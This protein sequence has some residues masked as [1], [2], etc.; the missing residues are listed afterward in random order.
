[1]DQDTLRLSKYMAELGLC[2]RSEADRLIE[3]G[4]VRVDGQVV[5][6]LG[7]RVR[8]GQKV[9]LADTV[10]HNQPEVV[11]LVLHKPAG[12]DMTDDDWLDAARP[13]LSKA[14]H[15]ELDQSGIY[16][17]RR[18]LDRQHLPATLVEPATGL[19][20]FT[21]DKSLADRV[22]KDCEQEFLVWVEETITPEQITK[23]EKTA[24]FGDVVL[25]GLKASR[26]SDTQLRVVVRNPPVFWLSDLLETAGLTPVEV[27]RIRI[28]R[29][30]LG[31]LEEGQWRYLAPTERI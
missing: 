5:D 24:R 31:Q 7:C 28:G 17:L 6:T 1:M 25:K 12:I 27:K 13:V 26:Q 4:H 16:P 14:R 20:V 18:H 22:R 9:T 8:R 19:V 11:T 2:S 21:Q 23:L 3:A 29:L 30:A 10:R 15:S